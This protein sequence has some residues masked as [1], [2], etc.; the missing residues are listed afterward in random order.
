MGFGLEHDNTQELPAY[1][2]GYLATYFALPD[3]IYYCR[4]FP[5][6]LLLSSS[7]ALSLNTKGFERVT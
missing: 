4:S 6:L 5:I 3:S 1:L 7:F 2:P